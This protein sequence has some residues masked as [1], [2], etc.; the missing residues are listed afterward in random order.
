MTPETCDYSFITLI[1]LLIN[2]L[3]YAIL[4][5]P[6]LL[7]W[8]NFRHRPVESWSILI[9]LGC[10]LSALLVLLVRCLKRYRRVPL[11]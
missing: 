3:L 9:G 10:F 4:A 2:V 6:I 7:R 8:I 1:F 11:A 5:I